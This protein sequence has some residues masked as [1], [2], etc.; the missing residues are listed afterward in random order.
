[1]STPNKWFRDS[2]QHR[3]KNADLVEAR[4]FLKSELFDVD[5]FSSASS[6]D[7]ISKGLYFKYEV[8]ADLR[9]NPLI[10]GWEIIYDWKNTRKVYVQFDSLEEA[11]YF[12]MRWC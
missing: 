9:N 3:L 1:M 12:K 8:A 6:M 11:M 5:N 7:E 10:Q 2:W 4:I